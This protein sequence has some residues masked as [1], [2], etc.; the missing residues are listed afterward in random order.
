MN[1]TKE[2]IAIVMPCFNEGQTIISF[3]KELEQS[4]KS[5][6]DNFFIIVVDDCSQDNTRTLLE[7]FNFSSPNITLHLLGLK[8]NLGHQGAIHQG[9]LYASTLNVSHAV[10]MDSDGED[11]PAAIPFLL[12]HKEFEI[13]KVKRGKRSEGI[14]FRIFYFFYKLLF[15]AITGTVLDFGNYCLINRSVLERVQHTSFIHFPAFLLKQKAQKTKIVWDRAHRIDGKSKMSFT[16][17]FF[18][19]LRSFIE[20][21]EDLLMLFMK[22][23]FVIMAIL[24]IVI[25]DILYQKFIAHTAI[26]G[27][28]STLAIGLANLAVMCIGFFIL[29]VLLLNLIHQQNRSSYRDIYTILKS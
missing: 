18:H 19:A 20:F 14:V 7:Q 17:L 28:S 27:W 8:F 2:L 4:I 13:V 3:L 21:A 26:L 25:G 1:M 12:Q 24:L 9:L 16:N 11:D 15:R 10:V 23:F 22:I 5:L 6:Y 29:G